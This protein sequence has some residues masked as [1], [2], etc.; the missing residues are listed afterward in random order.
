MLVMGSLLNITNTALPIP[1]AR[2]LS[3]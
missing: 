3:E 2:N 1:A